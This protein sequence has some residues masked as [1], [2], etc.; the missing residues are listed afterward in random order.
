[1]QK[2]SYLIGIHYRLPLLIGRIPQLFF[3]SRSLS[4]VLVPSGEF[5]MSATCCGVVASKCT[6]TLHTRQG[7]FCNL[8]PVRVTRSASFEPVV[9]PPVYAFYT[10]ACLRRAVRADTHSDGSKKQMPTAKD[11]FRYVWSF[12]GIV[13]RGVSVVTFINDV[14]APVA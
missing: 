14:A 10:H 6:C 8:F 5:L 13:E 11:A 12:S 7:H 4:L 3:F 9:T 2:A 1:M